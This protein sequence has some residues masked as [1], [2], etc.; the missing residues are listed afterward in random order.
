MPAVFA[1]RRQTKPLAAGASA[2]AS[3]ANTPIESLQVSLKDIHEY[4][5][6]MRIALKRNDARMSVCDA[7]ALP[8]KKTVQATVLSQPRRAGLMMQRWPKKPKES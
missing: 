6:E 2:S 7:V 4:T 8:E 5:P 3:S 1:K